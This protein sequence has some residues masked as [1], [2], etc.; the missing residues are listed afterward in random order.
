MGMSRDASYK[1]FTSFLDAVNSAPE[2]DISMPTTLNEWDRIYNKYKR[3]NTHEIMTGCVGCIDGFFRELT[4][5]LKR[6][7][8]M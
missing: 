5:Q 4:S 7:F 8:Q 1:T 6:K 2:L 3:K